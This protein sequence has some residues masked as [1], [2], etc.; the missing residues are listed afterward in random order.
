MDQEHITAGEFT[1]AF[2]SLERQMAAGFR[3]IHAR[4]D[5]VDAESRDHG[6]DIAALKVKVAATEKGNRKSASGWGGAIAGIVMLAAEAIKSA[7]GR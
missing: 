7:L 3:G 1:R 2:Q 4:L 6:E 5:N